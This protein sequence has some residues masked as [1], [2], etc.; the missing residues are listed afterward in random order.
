MGNRKDNFF[1]FNKFN[2]NKIL[3]GYYTIQIRISQVVSIL[4]FIAVFCF[5]FSNLGSNKIVW[6]ISLS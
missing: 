5:I 4:S 1:V 6:C 3:L 2:V